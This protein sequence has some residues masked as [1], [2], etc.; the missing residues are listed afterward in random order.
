[1]PGSSGVGRRALEEFSEPLEMVVPV[2][3]CRDA[4]QADW[5]IVALGQIR[6]GPVERLLHPRLDRRFVTD[7]VAS[8]AADEQKLAAR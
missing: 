2:V 3:V 7:V 5:R 1:M 8:V 4:I 6:S